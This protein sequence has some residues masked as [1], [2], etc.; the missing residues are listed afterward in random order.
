MK[1]PKGEPLH[2]DLS[3]N[4]TNLKKLVEDLKKNSFSGIVE[5]LG[6]N[7]DGLILIDSGNISAVRIKRGDGNVEFGKNFLNHIYELSEVEELMISTYRLPP[8]SIIYLTLFLNS[9]PFESDVLK[10]GENIEAII[11]KFKKKGGDFFIEVQFDKNLGVGLL[12][13]QEGILMDGL[14]SLLGKELTTS[15]KAINGIIEGAK[16]L[17]AKV[18]VYKTEF[19]PE[20]TGMMTLTFSKEEK[21]EFFNELFDIFV[22]SVKGSNKNEFELMVRETCLELADK[23]PMLDPFLGDFLYKDGKV[24]INTLEEDENL[25]I[26]VFKLFEELIGKFKDKKWKFDITGFKNNAKKSLADK[27]IVF[28]EKYDIEKKIDEL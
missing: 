17:G 6:V 9:K 27:N 26:S 23:F 25:V 3:S 14:L 18:D 13:M 1:I 22:N 24:E 5:A 21:D 12:F 2:K 15:E 8:E 7:I 19:D 20:V 4:F 10:S 28:Y 16:E 11:D